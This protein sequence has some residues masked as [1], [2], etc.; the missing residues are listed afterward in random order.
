MGSATISVAH[1]VVAAAAVGPILAA[2]D[3]IRWRSP[4][5]S[6][7][8]RRQRRRNG[9]IGHP[10]NREPP[11]RHRPCG[12]GAAQLCGP[13]RS[14]RNWKRI[15]EGQHQPRGRPRTGRR[16]DAAGRTAAV[17]RAPAN[18]GKEDPQGDRLPPGVLRVGGV[19]FPMK[20]RADAQPRPAVDQTRTTFRQI[21]LDNHTL[22]AEPQPTWM[23]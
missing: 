18:L 15:S 5:S 20:D 10:T 7:F 2:C 21:F 16:A 12:T 9:C 19:P 8:F 4:L 22:G 6:V 14:L 17:S 3:A 1:G 23:G 13:G 11:Q